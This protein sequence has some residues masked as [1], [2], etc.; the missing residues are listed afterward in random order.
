MLARMNPRWLALAA[1]A[2]LYAVLVPSWRW[3]VRRWGLAGPG[4]PPRAALSEREYLARR[5]LRALLA[6]DFLVMGPAGALACVAAVAVALTGPFEPE[7]IALFLL[8]VGLLVFFV[9]VFVLR[10]SIRRMER[11]RLEAPSMEPPPPS[12]RPVSAFDAYLRRRAWATLVAAGLIVCGSLAAWAVPDGQLAWLLL[13]DNDAIRAG[14]VWRLLTVVFVH[15]NLLHL[16]MNVAVLVSEGSLFERLAGAARQL[17]VLAAGTVAG[18]L[19]SF[20]FIDQPSVGASG[21]V[22]AVVAAVAAFGYRR[23]ALLPETSRARFF[24]SIVQFFVLNAVVT[25]AIPGVD[26]AAHL[27]GVL[28]GAL[29]GWFSRPT[30]ETAAALA[31]AVAAQRLGP[32]PPP[33]G[34]AAPER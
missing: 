15:G 10:R 2:A 12:D 24:R 29:L 19:L 17:T 8:P 21:G 13:K 34:A 9:P 3:L 20:A 18:S 26:W 16:A 28:C 5:S 7:M 32:P 14:Q 11:E 31:A 33:V 23:R 22:L 4:A 27:G 30:R 6:F 25:L 1:F